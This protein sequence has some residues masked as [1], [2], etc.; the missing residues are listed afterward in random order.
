MRAFFA[1]A[2][3]CDPWSNIACLAWDYPFHWKVKMAKWSSVGKQVR[4]NDRLW[5]DPNERNLHADNL[6]IDAIIQGRKEII[7][8]FGG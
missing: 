8:H 5:T 3:V 4:N 1:D 6:Y 7:F 2:W